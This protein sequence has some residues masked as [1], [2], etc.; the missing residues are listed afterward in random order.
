MPIKEV[1]TV[2]INKLLTVI[3]RRKLAIAL[4]AL[5]M[6]LAFAAYAYYLPS[7]YEAKALLTIAPQANALSVQT[8]TVEEQLVTVREIVLGRPLIEKVIGEFALYPP[9]GDAVEDVRSRI[10]VDVV[11]AKAFHVG[12]QAEDPQLAMRVA[13]RLADLF[14]SQTASAQTQTIAQTTGLLQEGL[15]SLRGRLAVQNE[16]IQ[17]YKEKVG[18]ALPE[19]L[20]TNLKA[21]EVLDDRLQSANARIATDQSTRAAAVK[22]MAELEKRGALE[23]AV[24][25]DLSASQREL[26]QRRLD[27]AKARAK[28]TEKNTEVK[29]LVRQVNDLEKAQPQGSSPRAEPSAVTLRYLQL[30]AELEGIDQRLVSERQELTL[31]TS[32]L[33]ANRVQVQTVPQH[34]SEMALLMRDYGTTQA[35]YQELL[36]KQN[37]AGIVAG[38]ATTGNG[39]LFTVAEPARPPRTPYSPQRARIILMGLFAGLG[40]GGLI[41]FAAEQ[42]NTSFLNAEEFCA[43][44]SLQVLAEVPTISKVDGGRTNAERVVTVRHPSSVAAELY[45]TLA[46]KVRQRCQGKSPVILAVTSAT[47]GEGKSLTSLNV[48]I[49]L[50]KSFRGKVLLIDADL[51]RP[52]LHDYLELDRHGK[53][54]FGDLLLNP[55][56]DIHDYIL[57]YNGLSVMPTFGRIANPLGMLSASSARTLLER[58]SREFA[59]VV[60]DSPPIVPIADGHVLTN[61][62]DYVLL[63]A[64][65]R[66]T[67]RELFKLA[68]ESLDCSTVIGVALNDVDLKHSRYSTAYRYYQENYQ[69]KS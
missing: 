7:R 1:D 10:A 15:Q 61:L 33:E 39:L 52:M 34:E 58:I 13:N 44:S 22:E 6:A 20:G 3:R 2:S 48:S 31:L 54:G 64:R 46:E 17:N 60:L 57:E 49:A 12:F 38:P 30:G 40:L 27:L 45:F 11:S 55:D 69:V 53:K 26:E 32:E 8:P 43:F 56:D 4:P 50:A 21:I 16:R 14:V 63:I 24:S 47:G 41:A 37:V 28:Y 66:R 42:M 67:P 35:S 5:L 68:T 62:A 9:T 59:F 23:P 25:K 29:T 36:A 51:R 19:R 18:G 65:A